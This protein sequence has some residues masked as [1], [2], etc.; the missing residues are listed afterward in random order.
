MNLLR[1]TICYILCECLHGILLRE[2]YVFVVQDLLQKRLVNFFDDFRI[3]PA[4]Q[5]NACHI[6]FFLI[7]VVFVHPADVALFRD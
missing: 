6:E 5:Y 4:F 3:I 7:G 1:K 2:I